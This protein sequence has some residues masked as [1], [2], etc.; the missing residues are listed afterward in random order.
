MK[1]SIKMLAVAVAG[2]LSLA[3]CGGAKTE[4]ETT[5]GIPQPKVSCDV[6]ESNFDDKAV[7]T[8]KADGE[9]TW[10][11]Q[12]LQADFKDYFDGVIAT[13]EK[14]NPGTKVNWIDQGGAEDFDNLIATQAQG[15]QMADVINVPSSTI[16]ALSAKD[17]L[18]DLDVKAPNLGSNT[19]PNLFDSTK[20]GNEDHHTAVP[21]YM[22]PPVTLY[23]TEVLERNG[24]DP[25]TPPATVEDLFTMGKKVAEAGNDDYM[26]WGNPDWQ[27]AIQW[28]AMGVKI[29]NDDASEF[30]FADDQKALE[31]LTGMAELNELGVI[32]PDSFTG[33]SDPGKE[34]NKGKLII[35]TPNPGFVRNIQKNNAEV[36]AVTDA[37]PY[38]VSEDGYVPVEP[39]YIAVSATT[40]N[41]PLAVKFAEFLTSDEMLFDWARNGGAV[42]MTTSQGA[43]DKLLAD[44]PAYATEDPVRGELFEIMVETTQNAKV[45]PA[46]MYLTG[47]VKQTLTQA[48]VDATQGKIAPADALQKAQNEMNKLLKSLL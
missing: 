32:P 47:K 15:C 24:L 40:G 18:M 13:F 26:V 30:V 45:N 48:V 33:E 6:P 17:F 43:L 41:A 8:S 22:G 25:K 36:Y 5:G 39:Q 23:N 11:T 31:W 34:Y 28:T 10:M 7:D 42:T 46:S 9:I 1:K 4:A 35:G 12:G 14:E 19:L 27:I 2:T 20:I 3:G 21:W 44:P 16:M 38:P 37:A 29:M